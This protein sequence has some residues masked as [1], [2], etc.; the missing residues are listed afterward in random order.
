MHRQHGRQNTAR[1]FERRARIRIP[2]TQLPEGRAHAEQPGVALYFN[3]QNGSKRSSSSKGYDDE[4]EFAG[5]APVQS[6]W[7]GINSQAGCGGTRARK[8]RSASVPSD[9]IAHTCWAYAYVAHHDTT[10][11]AKTVLKKSVRL[12][13]GNIDAWY[14]LGTLLFKIGRKSTLALLKAAT[15]QRKGHGKLAG[16]QFQLRG[17]DKEG[18]SRTSQQANMR[19]PDIAELREP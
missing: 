18:A 10:P 7:R 5:A 13:P 2:H 8:Q 11:P 1:F 16:E 15:E 19:R 17:I 14:A 3:H 6:V 9:V 4:S 12:A